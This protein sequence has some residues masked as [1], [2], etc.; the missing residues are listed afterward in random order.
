M[1]KYIIT[2]E[3]LQELHDG[4]PRH[5]EFLDGS[6]LEEYKE[7]KPKL[8]TYKNKFE[9]TFPQQSAKGVT[10]PQGSSFPET[11]MSNAVK[12][13]FSELEGKLE[14]VYQYIREGFEKGEALPPLAERFIKLSNTYRGGSDYH[15]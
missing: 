9:E 3:Q 8:I 7:D 14:Y 10:I 1:K 15:S 13:R 2:E 6:I 11:S 12:E 5:Y 4:T